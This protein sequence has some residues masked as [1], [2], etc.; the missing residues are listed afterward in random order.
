MDKFVM[1]LKE[2][3]FSSLIRADVPLRNYSLTHSLIRHCTADQ[4]HAREIRGRPTPPAMNLS[5]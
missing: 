3:A 2:E 4:F 1:I 5:K